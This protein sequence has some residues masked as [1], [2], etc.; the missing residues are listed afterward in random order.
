MDLKNNFVKAT[1]AAAL[2]IAGLATVN[3]VKPNAV[4]PHVKAATQQVKIN[5]V[6]NYGINIWD[7]YNHGKFTG[8]RAQHGTTWNVL[9]TEFD[10]KGRTWYEIGE[11]QWIMAKY[12]VS[13]DQKVK[14]NTVKKVKKAKKSVQA[15]GDASGIV[16][17][18]KAQQGIPYVYGGTSTNGFDCSG[19]VQYVYQNAAGVKLPRTS[20]AQSTQGTPV[21]MNNLQPGDLLF[22]GGEG[23]A[24]HV[25]IYVGN[26]KYV[27]APA[28][29]QSVTVQSMTY[30]RPQFAKRVLG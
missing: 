10:A 28:P 16:A 21:S 18:A 4:A 7:N 22:W 2:S 24:Y 13:A 27:H 15:T 29:G 20:Q 1:A 26:G 12:T 25:G 30:F 14:A 6:P 19:L 3:A 5:Y 8:K 23:S 11:G 9:D 17:L